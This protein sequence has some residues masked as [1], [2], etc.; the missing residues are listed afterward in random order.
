MP[1]AHARLEG[2]PT[3]IVLNFR[4]RVQVTTLRLLDPASRV[5]RLSM[6]GD[7]APSYEK[8]ALVPADLKPGHYKI[9]WAA[10]SSDGHSVSGTVPFEV[11]SSSS[12]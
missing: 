3:E 7:M 10:I 11:R 9:D 8:R 12:R 2:A 6:D 1:S 4:E 5:I